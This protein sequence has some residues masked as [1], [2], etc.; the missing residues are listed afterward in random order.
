M[1][2][3]NLGDR[4]TLSHSLHIPAAVPASGSFAQDLLLREVPLL[5]WPF[6]KQ[7]LASGLTIAA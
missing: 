3:L 1:A 6:Q 4:D 7:V 5:S 2:Y